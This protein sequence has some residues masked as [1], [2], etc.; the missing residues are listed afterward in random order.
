MMELRQY[1]N[2]L[3]KWWWLIAASVVIATVSSYFGTRAIAPTYQASTTLMVGQ[4]LQNPN[5]NAAEF[6]TG[7]VL[8]QSYVDLVRRQP[9][10]EGTLKTLGL[11]W[12]WRV[13]QGMVSSR[14]VAGTQLLEISVLDTDPQRAPVLADEIARQLILQSPAGSDPEMAANRE[15]VLAQIEELETEAVAPRGALLRH[16]APGLQ[17]GQETEGVVLVNAELPGQIRDAEGAVVLR[18]RLQEVQGADDGADEVGRFRFPHGRSCEPTINDA[19][20]KS[21]RADP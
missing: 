12:N 8:A 4:A 6:Y 13:L 15:F 9:V 16:V 20:G 21:T 14:V 18:E 3:L 1:A 19:S 17:R 5:P 10:M 11:T 2:V 7:Q